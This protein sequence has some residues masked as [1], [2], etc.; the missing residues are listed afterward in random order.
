T[1]VPPRAGATPPRAKTS[2]RSNSESTMRSR[3]SPPAPFRTARRSCCCST[4]RSIFSETRSSAVL[5]RL[6][7]RLLRALRRRKFFGQRR[8]GQALVDDLFRFRGRSLA[9]DRALGDF[10]LVD[11]ARL[12]RKALTHIVIVLGDV[13]ARLARHRSV[14]GRATFRTRHADRGRH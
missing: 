9:P 11:A 7:R 6:F 5:V 10:A 4:R 12:V 8:D 2:K 3:G 13:L 14:P 1:C